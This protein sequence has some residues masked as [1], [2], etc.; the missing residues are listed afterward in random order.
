MITKEVIKTLYKKY[1]RRAKSFDDL[2]IALLFETVGE[3][4]NINIDID[5]NMLTVGSIDAKSI[6]HSI[7]LTHVHAFVP[8]EE[9]TAIV[10]HSSIIFLNRNNTT[11][12]VHLKPISPT[13]S[14]RLRDMF[15][16]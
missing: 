12:S 10:L 6:F 13:I 9:W 15:K 7:P 11:V 3:I 1:P 14:D 16:K 8:F 2:D 5:T 4:H